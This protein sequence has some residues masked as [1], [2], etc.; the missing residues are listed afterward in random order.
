MPVIH[1]LD[2]E[3]AHRLA[4]LAGKYRVFPKSQFNDTELLVSQF[5]NSKSY[6][7]NFLVKTVFC[8]YSY[9]LFS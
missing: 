1:R 9:K 4:V 7:F 8:I 2:P 3:N 6:F 5:T